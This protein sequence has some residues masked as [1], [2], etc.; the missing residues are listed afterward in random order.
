MKALELI[1]LK[2]KTTIS[3]VG[4][5]RKETLKKRCYAFITDLYAIVFIN[6]YMAFAWSAIIN[7]YVA[8]TTLSNPKASKLIFNGISNLSL[9]IIF[10]GYFFFSYYLGDGRS[11]GKML[12]GLKVYSNENRKNSLS[13]KECLSR[14]LGYLF[15]NYLLYIPFLT[16]F[17]RSDMKSINDFISQTTVYSD[18][19]IAFIES[20]ESSAAN[21]SEDAS[22]QIDLFPEDPNQRFLNIA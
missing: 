11:L 1:N 18:K 14:S 2:D 20:L 5:S 17:V 15:S 21:Q 3:T 13:A 7:N 19:E 9:P 6:K 10:M 8:N 16:S 12:F 4:P 22:E